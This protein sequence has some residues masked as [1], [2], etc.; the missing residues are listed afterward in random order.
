MVVSDFGC[1]NA[2]DLCQKVPVDSSNTKI[3]KDHMNDAYILSFDYGQ[4]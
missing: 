1:F 4:V 3:T 2:I